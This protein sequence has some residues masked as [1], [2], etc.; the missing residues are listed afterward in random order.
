MK[1]QKNNI[2]K[3]IIQNNHVNKYTK[4][5][6]F[7]NTLDYYEDYYIPNKKIMKIL[8]INKKN[9]IR[10]LKQLKDDDMIS[11]FYKGS[12][13]FFTFIGKPKETE[14]NKETNKDIYEIFSYDW[15]NDLENKD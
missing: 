1:K 5:L 4:L 11:I 12:K 13:R 7:L 2:Y 15:L 10:L 9:T 14:I 8:N 3:I 6:L